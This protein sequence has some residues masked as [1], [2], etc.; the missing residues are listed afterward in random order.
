M[1]ENI[2]TEDIPTGSYAI[3]A[4][5]KTRAVEVRYERVIA[6]DMGDT[7]LTVLPH[8]LAVEAAEKIR[9]QLQTGGPRG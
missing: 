1:S 7:D 5:G 8:R 3:H 2:P 9:E 4:L 6:M